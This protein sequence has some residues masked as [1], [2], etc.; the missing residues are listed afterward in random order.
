M[1]QSQKPEGMGKSMHERDL[2]D[3]TY[4]QMI[5]EQDHNVTNEPT[6]MHYST[7]MNTNMRASMPHRPCEKEE[8]DHYQDYFNQW[9]QSLNYP[10]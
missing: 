7:S 9:A 6:S 3:N 8:F 2:Q 1:N 10:G 5:P 4:M